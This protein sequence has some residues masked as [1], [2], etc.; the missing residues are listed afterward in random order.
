MISSIILV[1]SNVLLCLV[2]LSQQS[3]CSFKFEPK[4]RQETACQKKT[5][6]RRAYDFLFNLFLCA[7]SIYYI[8]HNYVIPQAMPHA[9]PQTHSF[10]YPRRLL[11][12]ST[13]RLS[14]LHGSSTTWFQTSRYCRAKV[15]FNSSNWVRHG[16]STTFETGLKA[17]C[18]NS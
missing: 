9:I 10:F 12:C 3:G 16:S 1:N 7:I 4:K 17:S 2:G 11:P 14:V 8:P 5:R 15:E 18:V 13:A 6:Q